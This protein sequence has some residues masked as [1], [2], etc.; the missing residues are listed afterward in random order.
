MYTGW[1]PDNLSEV[2]YM[3]SRANPKNKAA[4]L[5]LRLTDDDL[6]LI[7]EAAAARAETVTEYVTRAAVESAAE[8]IADQRH[9]ELNDESWDRFLTVLEAPQLPNE[10]LNALM[11]MPSVLGL[12]ELPERP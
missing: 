11:D 10:R 3:A 9:F 4:R 6:E 1:V 2:S 12:R 8:T 7:V 5:N